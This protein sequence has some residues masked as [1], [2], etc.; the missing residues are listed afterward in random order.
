[1][2]NN[3]KTVN[4]RGCMSVSLYSRTIWERGYAKEPEFLPK[5]LLQLCAS[6]LTSSPA[7]NPRQTKSAQARPCPELFEQLKV[8]P[9][10]LV[11][12]IVHWTIYC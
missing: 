11:K 2:L 6:L 3:G 10:G 1:M 9:N 7:K 5:R 8:R 4:L 12:L